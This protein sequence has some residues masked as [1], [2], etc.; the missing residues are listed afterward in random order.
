MRPHGSPE[1]LEERRRKV[2]ESLNQRISLHE[3]ARRIGC[4]A[5]SVM[6][7]R[8]ALLSGGK[9]HSKPNPCQAGLPG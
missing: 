6:R 1:S 7:W 9:R 8:D 4:N 3:I 5:S 2:V